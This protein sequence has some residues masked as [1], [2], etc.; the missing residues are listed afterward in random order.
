MTTR[1]CRSILLSFA[2]VTLVACAH[3]PPTVLRIDGSSPEAFQASWDRMYRSLR[4]PERSR[5]DVAILPIALG[6]YH[7]LLDVPPSLLHTGIGPQTIRAEIDGLS[8]P[9][10]ITLAQKQPIKVSGPSYP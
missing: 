8:Y 6:K 9:E 5:L 1:K 4:P 2:M 10:I 3:A 7:S